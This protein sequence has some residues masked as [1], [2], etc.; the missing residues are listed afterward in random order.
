MKTMQ[1]YPK[2]LPLVSHLLP[3]SLSLKVQSLYKKLSNKTIGLFNLDFSISITQITTEGLF[4]VSECVLPAEYNF[5]VNI[6]IEAYNLNFC[7]EVVI[8]ESYA[9][10]S[11]QYIYEC[12]FTKIS[13]RVANKLVFYYREALK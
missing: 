2:E 9:L 3:L 8:R 6:P 12:D 5:I 11:E 10:D 13:K 7:E 1:T 4:F